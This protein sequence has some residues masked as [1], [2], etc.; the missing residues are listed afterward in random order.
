MWYDC[1]IWCCVLF[2]FMLAKQKGVNQSELPTTSCDNHG[3]YANNCGLQSIHVQIHIFSIALVKTKW[4][5]K[6][7]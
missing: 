6:L 7:C 1:G 2:V 4:H 5:L 3:D